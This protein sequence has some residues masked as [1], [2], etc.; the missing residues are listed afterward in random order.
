MVIR[1]ILKAGLNFIWPL[2][3]HICDIALDPLSDMVFCERC[4]GGFRRNTLAP[5]GYINRYYDSVTSPYIYEGIMR[6]AIHLFK[7]K[8]DEAAGGRLAELLCE[9]IP[10]DGIICGADVIVP[11]PLYKRNLRKRRYNQAMV[12]A[13]MVSERSGLPITESLKKHKATPA[14][15]GLS[16][17]KRA[18]NV[19]GAFICEDARRING[20]RVLLVDDVYTTGN[21]AD[22]ASR[23]LKKA[24]A[25]SVDVLTLA[26]SL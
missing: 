11:L 22:E 17:K 23:V 26:R 14:Q 12:L 3:C 21:T 8:R 13:K 4:E 19:K 10:D 7:Y 1:N 18:S 25:R 16:A 20:K 6:E 2:K 9:T 5:S 15:T 24:G